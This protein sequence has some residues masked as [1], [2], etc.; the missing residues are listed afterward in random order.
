MTIRAVY[1]DGVFRPLVPVSIKGGT[2]VD[3]RY[4]P[5]QSAPTTEQIKAEV[6]RILS[7]SQDDSISFDGLDHDKVLYGEPLSS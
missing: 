5:K 6:K 1:Q 3:I 4:E 7:L 2:E